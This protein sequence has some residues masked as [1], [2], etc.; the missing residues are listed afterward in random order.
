[1]APVIVRNM[2]GEDIVGEREGLI[3]GEGSGLCGIDRRD[4]E[5]NTSMHA[6]A[7]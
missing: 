7:V 5:D 2:A 3:W 4:L 1:V 6:D